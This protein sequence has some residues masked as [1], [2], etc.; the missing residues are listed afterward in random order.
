MIALP[1]NRLGVVRQQRLERD[2]VIVL[3]DEI[4]VARFTAGEFGHVLE[5]M[6]G[7]LLV[8][9]H[10]RLFT[11]SSLVS[12]F[13]CSISCCRGASALP[14]KTVHARSSVISST[15][16]TDSKFCEESHVTLLCI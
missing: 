8:M 15:L 16:A 6:K 7:N 10:H 9:I 11:Q 14:R 2:E 3:H 5:Q 1:P 12:A 4:P 13:L